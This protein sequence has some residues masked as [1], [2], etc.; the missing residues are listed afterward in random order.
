MSEIKIWLLWNND[1]IIWGDNPFVWSEVYVI[2]KITE[3][4]GGGGGGGLILPNK[5]PWRD[6]EKK[7]K[8]DNFSEDE[9]KIFLQVVARINGIVT[10]EVKTVDKDLKKQITVEHI[11]K[12]L[13]SFG[14][15]VEV[16]VKN[17]KKR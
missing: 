15:K 16:K 4:Y 12:T 13:E 7:L 17:I 2:Q 1:T 6:L 8:K 14:Q 10:S 3:S 11:K 5:N 9:R